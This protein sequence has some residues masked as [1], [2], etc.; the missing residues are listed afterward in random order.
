MENKYYYIKEYVNYNGSKF[1]VKVKLR[2]YF[3]FRWLVIPHDGSYS[4]DS[5]KVALEELN[6]LC[7]KL[8]ARKNK[9]IKKRLKHD[10]V[11]TTIPSHI[12]EDQYIKYT[13][14]KK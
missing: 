2:Y 3:S 12:P 13:T 10:I 1:T 14:I 7:M 5:Y 9:K 4:Y 11:R 8:Q 6:I